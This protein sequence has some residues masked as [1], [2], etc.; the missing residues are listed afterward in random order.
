V[1][2]ARSYQ[3]CLESAKKLKDGESIILER[4][5]NAILFG[6]NYLVSA[7]FFARQMPYGVFSNLVS[8]S[9]VPILI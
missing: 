9:A 2:L 5:G 8:Q 1:V 7:N 6:R 4:E 3:D